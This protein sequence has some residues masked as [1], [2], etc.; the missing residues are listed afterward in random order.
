MKKKK[1]ILLA[2]RDPTTASD[3]KVRLERMGCA[4]L[5]S[6]PAEAPDIA[7]HDVRLPPESG[8][9][10]AAG[11]TP[12][13]LLL[14]DGWAGI[15]PAFP[16]TSGFL[17]LPCTDGALEAA[18]GEAW[19]AGEPVRLLRRNGDGIRSLVALSAE[20]VALND[21]EGRILL[22]S[23]AAEQMFGYAPESVRLAPFV[24]LLDGGARERYAAAAAA[25]LEG[26]EAGPLSLEARRADGTSFQAVLTLRALALED[27]PCAAVLIRPAA[28]DPFRTEIRRIAHDI[29]N[30]LSA[31]LGY[32]ELARDCLEDKTALEE[33]TG[34]L[35]KAS[36]RAQDLV[37][38]L[39][40]V[41]R[42]AP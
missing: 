20:A 17:A 39:M 42:K 6:S 37:A 16:G 10:T 28:G 12:T 2:V 5:G 4:V 41:A 21:R 3:L 35:L 32:S 15:P 30:T 9:T 13:I 14:P 36:T 7:L 25:L 31:I 22:F 40:R 38:Q 1:R 29:N 11:R 26:R 23:P 33:Y 8:S 34:E 24:Q 18:V 27:G 19:R